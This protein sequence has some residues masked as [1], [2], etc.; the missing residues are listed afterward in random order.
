MGRTPDLRGE[1]RNDDQYPH[2]NASRFPVCMIRQP[3]ASR[4]PPGILRCP[5]KAIRP[6]SPPLREVPS[7][8]GNGRAPV[9]V[10]GV[11]PGPVGIAFGLTHVAA[12]NSA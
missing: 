2:D 6:G 8:P 5:V 11:V 3:P 10:E 1:I 4:S 9:R 12:G 7:G